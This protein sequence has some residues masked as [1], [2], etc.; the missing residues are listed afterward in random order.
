MTEPWVRRNLACLATAAVSLGGCGL[1]PPE[2]EAP[3]IVAAQQRLE[4][5]ECGDGI[6]DL[7]EGGACAIDCVGTGYCGDGQCD[8]GETCGSCVDC[9][10]CG[11][12]GGAGAGAGGPPGASGA[13]GMAGGYGQ[14][15]EGGCGDPL[16]CSNQDAC[17][18]P[19]G[20]VAPALCANDPCE[21]FDGSSTSTALAD[22]ELVV[23]TSVSGPLCGA[24]S[25]FPNWP[26]GASG[27]KATF[28]AT[29]STSRTCSACEVASSAS[30][31]G[32]ASGFLCG[33]MATGNGQGHQTRLAERCVLCS[34][35]T[36]WK[37]VCSDSMAHERETTSLVGTALSG[38]TDQ[39][40]MKAWLQGLAG[41]S[42][43]GTYLLGKALMFCPTITAT[44]SGTVGVSASYSSTDDEVLGGEDCPASGQNCV[45]RDG[46]AGPSLSASAT[47]KVLCGNVFVDADVDAQAFATL[48]TT[49][50]YGAEAPACADGT[51]TTAAGF[52]TVSGRLDLGMG[53]GPQR[54]G[55]RARF[56]C[57]LSVTSKSCVPAEGDDGSTPGENHCWGNF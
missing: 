1:S 33:V 39:Y 44:T 40:N 2:Q 53:T 25:R 21:G 9:G 54:L 5:G 20:C 31:N 19:N 23:P 30:V 12:T 32:T 7:G 8:S 22:V 36:N 45:S 46:T 11:G 18:D 56:S 13:G 48:G 34:E 28:S 14:G 38:F 37:K 55:W 43:L 42:R 51:C 29:A 10:P 17:T 57:D 49:T 52:A 50:K 24:L 26:S 47:A 41:G 6:C 35:E 16:G 3:T 27:I 15:G 4:T